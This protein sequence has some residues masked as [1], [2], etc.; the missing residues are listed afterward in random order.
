[1]ISNKNIICKRIDAL[2]ESYF[3]LQ[4]YFIIDRYSTNRFS[5]TTLNSFIYQ[6]LSPIKMYIPFGYC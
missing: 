1:M 6:R 4:I 5:D 2:S 3:L